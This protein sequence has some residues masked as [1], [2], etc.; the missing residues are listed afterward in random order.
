MKYCKMLFFFASEQYVKCHCLLQVLP[1]AAWIAH[2]Q[3]ISFIMKFI[4]DIAIYFFKLHEP[5]LTFIHLK[6]GLAGSQILLEELNVG[7]LRLHTSR[8]LF[9]CGPGVK[10]IFPISLIL[11]SENT[12]GFRVHH[13]SN[14]IL[15]CSLDLITFRHFSFSCEEGEKVSW[16]FITAHTNTLSATEDGG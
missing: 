14:T 9:P 13:P 15:T 16:P 5:E 10:L 6:S 4:S 7:F 2:H 12:H 11:H 3:L 8:Q 1:A